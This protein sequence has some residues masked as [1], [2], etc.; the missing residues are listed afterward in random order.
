[1][2]SRKKKQTTNEMIAEIYI[3]MAENVQTLAN[4]VMS[5]V[6]DVNAKAKKD[7]KI[8]LDPFIQLIV[9]YI[10]N[11]QTRLVLMA[12]YITKVYINKR[13][14]EKRDASF[15][16]LSQKLF[17]GCD[18]PTELIEV[19]RSLFHQLWENFMDAGEKEL[20]FEIFDNFN[21]MAEDWIQ[22]EGYKSLADIDDWADDYHM[23]EEIRQKLAFDSK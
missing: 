1:M 11:Q 14:I 17:D 7:K 12:N 18:I 8:P 16:F 10:L 19:V 4:N 13:K 22:L 21:A 6:S 9:N 3:A 15:F 23:F 5:I 2:A 20:V